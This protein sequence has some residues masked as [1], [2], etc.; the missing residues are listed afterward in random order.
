M[1]PETG[2]IFNFKKYA[3]H[4]G[5]GIRTTVFLK[6]CPLDCRWCHNPES[7]KAGPEKITKILQTGDGKSETRTEI[8][9]REMA[10]GEVVAEIEKDLI[11]YDES[12]GG[13][14]FSGGEPLVQHGFLRALLRECRKREI[15]TA[16]DTSG[17]APESVI[18]D[19]AAYTDLFLYD[20]KIMNPEMHKRYTGV[21]NE[22]ILENLK[23]LIKLGKEIM[24]RFPLIPGMTDDE[25]NIR[26]I[27]E[28]AAATGGI[29][30]VAVLPY[31][32]VAGAKYIRMKEKNPM[33]GVNPPDEETVRRVVSRFE[34]YGFHVVTGG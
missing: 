14:T 25:T 12:G 28:F 34:S 24:L 13:V 17:Y 23:Q 8:V 18:T 20:L 27:A 19:I 16:V 5:P 4:D 15:H 33:D 29:R 22:R 21:A 26:E 3:I 32:A 30:E 11:F 7:K 31:H 2:I 10:V 9:G 1:K 6:G